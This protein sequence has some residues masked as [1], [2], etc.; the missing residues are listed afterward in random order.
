[1]LAPLRNEVWDP[2]FV[3][4]KNF[5]IARERERER[6]VENNNYLEA[7]DIGAYLHNQRSYN[8][9]NVTAH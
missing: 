9:K 2:A 5:M 3:R 8:R 4:G 1:M 6:E 7:L